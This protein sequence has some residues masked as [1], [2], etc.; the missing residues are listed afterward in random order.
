MVESGRVWVCK[1]GRR[2]GRV[3]RVGRMEKEKETARGR[4][5]RRWNKGSGGAI[6]RGMEGREGGVD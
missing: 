2:R 1:L 6:L 4:R 3:V 5:E